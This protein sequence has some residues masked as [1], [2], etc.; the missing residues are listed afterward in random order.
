VPCAIIFDCEFLVSEG[1]CQRFWCGP[2]DPD[3]VVVQIGAVKLDLSGNFDILDEHVALIRPVDR[4]GVAYEIPELFT[5][6]TGINSALIAEK[7]M[8]F[9]AAI[10]ALGAFSGGARLWSWGKDELNLMAINCYVA[11]MTPPIPASR[12]DNACKLLLRAGMPYDDIRKTR[13]GELAGYFCLPDANPPRH[14]A[15]ED[16]RSVASV[17]RYLLREGRLSP[18]DFD[19]ITP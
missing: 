19:L 17:L 5:N 16:A 7:G 9:D 1:A 11:D 3:P 13:S 8:T 18:G 2:Y 10:A 12:F 6:L 14:D 15:L 4:H